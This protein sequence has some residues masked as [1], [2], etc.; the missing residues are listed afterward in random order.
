MK[1]HREQKSNGCFFLLCSSQT[2]C[3]VQHYSIFQ[4][5]SNKEKRLPVICLLKGKTSVQIALMSHI[6]FHGVLYLNRSEKE[7]QMVMFFC[8]PYIKLTEVEQIS[9]EYACCHRNPPTEDSTQSWGSSGNPSGVS[10]RHLSDPIHVRI[11]YMC[12]VDTWHPR[13]DLI[14]FPA[15]MSDGEKCFLYKL[16]LIQSLSVHRRVSL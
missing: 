15:N 5:F 7:Y 8:I 1:H 9:K 4:C 10:Q 14:S 16:H 13:S 2:P 12:R 11:R 3:N 6:D